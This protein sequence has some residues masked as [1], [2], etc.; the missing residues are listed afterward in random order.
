MLIID[1]KVYQRLNHYYGDDSISLLKQS[2]DITDQWLTFLSKEQMTRFLLFTV[3]LFAQWLK[4]PLK[5]VVDDLPLCLPHTCG[6]S[7]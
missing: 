6:H 2:E 1:S 4:T 7:Y 5:S 3:L